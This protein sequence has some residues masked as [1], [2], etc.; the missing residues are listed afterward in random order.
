MEKDANCMF[1][2]FEYNE[3]N[4]FVQ[5]QEVNVL[6]HPTDNIIDVTV[7]L[8]SVYRQF[9]IFKALTMAKMFGDKVPKRPKY[10]D[11]YA[12]EAGYKLRNAHSV[13]QLFERLLEERDGDT[14]V[15]LPATT[16]VQATTETSPG[17]EYREV[18]YAGGVIQA[19]RHHILNSSKSEE[20]KESSE[21]TPV[22][23]QD[24][25]I[26]LPPVTRT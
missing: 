4:R 19:N 20:T 17:R 9:V 21:L 5:N 25:S 11:L 15:T 7:L 22:T 23:K 6:F 1:L 14:Y 8:V 13:E 18:A 3:K 12:R 2:G 10:S 26:S 24:N 16:V